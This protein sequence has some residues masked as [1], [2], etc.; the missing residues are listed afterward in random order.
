[1]CIDKE[2]IKKFFRFNVRILVWYFRVGVCCS[3]KA[4]STAVRARVPHEGAVRFLGSE[5][6]PVSIIGGPGDAPNALKLLQSN[7]CLGPFNRS[8]KWFS[9]A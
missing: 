8:I 6:Y 2:K 1:M 4:E 9:I 5:N 3:P 7:Y